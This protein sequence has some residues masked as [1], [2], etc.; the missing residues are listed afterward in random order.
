MAVNEIA[1]RATERV[2]VS[3][4]TLL[5]AGVVAPSAFIATFTVEGAF[6]AGY[7]PIRH[8]VSLLSLGDGGLIQ[9]AAFIAGGLLFAAFG[10]GL[11]RRWPRTGAARRVPQLVI[12]VGGALVACGVFVADP[13]LGYPPGT[14]PGIPTE[15]SWHGGLHYLGAL[16]VFLGLASAIAISAR[17]A[18]VVA[19]RRWAAYSLASAAIVLGAWL[20]G[21]LLTGPSGIVEQAGLLQRVA[22]VAGFQWVTATALIELRKGA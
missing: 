2:G 1:A 22:V 16:V 19:S 17:Y 13:A 6:Q 9:V 21:F 7:D 10:M 8:F 11:R 5:L 3:T 15:I 12:V 18:P 14:P 20:G 4:R